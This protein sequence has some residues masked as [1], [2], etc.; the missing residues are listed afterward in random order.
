M[1]ELLTFCGIGLALLLV[2][3]FVGSTVNIWLLIG[4]AIPSALAVVWWAIRVIRTEGSDSLILVIFA[5]TGCAVWVCSLLL[6]FLIKN[7]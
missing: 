3:A 4:L 1:K 7:Y 6:S 5:I 2:G